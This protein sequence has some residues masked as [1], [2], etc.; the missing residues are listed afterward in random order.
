MT[1]NCAE[2]CPLPRLQRIRAAHGRL[3]LVPASGEKEKNCPQDTQQDPCNLLRLDS[4]HKT[5]PIVTLSKDQL[6]T[7]V[8][9]VYRAWLA[10]D[11]QRRRLSDEAEDYKG[12]GRQAD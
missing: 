1:S 3:L 2:C 6:K 11:W 10:T 4:M 9:S 8:F 12:G 5:G 7:I